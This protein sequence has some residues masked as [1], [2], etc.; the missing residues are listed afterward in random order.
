M[1]RGQGA[2][3]ISWLAAPT[4]ATPGSEPFLEDDSQDTL[5]LAGSLVNLEA[6]MATTSKQIT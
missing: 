1:S 4:V 6:S 2:L 5:I 3:T